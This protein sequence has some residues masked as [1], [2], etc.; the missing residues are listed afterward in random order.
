MEQS[1]WLTEGQAGRW[2]FVAL[3][4]QGQEAVGGGDD[5]TLVTGQS[6]SPDRA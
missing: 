6:G 3:A 5:C 2:R 1:D 4:L